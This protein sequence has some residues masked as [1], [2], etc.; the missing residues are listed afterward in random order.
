MQMPCSRQGLTLT[1]AV[2]LPG[3]CKV[4]VGHAPPLVACPLRGAVV[5]N[6][7]HSGPLSDTRLLATLGTSAA[8]PGTSAAQPDTPPAWHIHACPGAHCSPAAAVQQQHLDLVPV[9]PQPSWVE[10][11]LAGVTA[12][13]WAP[14]A[15]D[16]PLRPLGLGTVGGRDAG[17][18]QTPLHALQAAS[19]PV[20]GGLLHALS[21]LRVHGSESVQDKTRRMHRS[22]Q[23]C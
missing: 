8:Q 19:Q 16:G 6:L 3:V 1:A 12:G 2:G 20:E 4:Q 13:I 7:H 23:P 15:A 5:G 21:R 17:R 10:S 18:S 22:S 11:D 14:R 9:Q